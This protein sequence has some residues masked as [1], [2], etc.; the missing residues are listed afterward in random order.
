MAALK[1]A[2]QMEHRISR[3]MAAQERSLEQKDRKLLKQLGI[4]KL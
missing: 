1:N 2:Q 3:N 4:L